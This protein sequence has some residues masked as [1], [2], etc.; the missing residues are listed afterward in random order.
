MIIE[1][2]TILA[3]IVVVGV[4]LIFAQGFKVSSKDGKDKDKKDKGSN[5]ETK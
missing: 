1:T 5:T 2:N 3:I 4:V